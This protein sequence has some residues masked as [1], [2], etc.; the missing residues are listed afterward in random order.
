MT[1]LQEQ[2]VT[3]LK[4]GRIDEAERTF[5]RVLA[6]EPTNIAA[7][8]ALC[9]G[10]LRVG[11]TQRAMELAE[12][13][14]A[15]A[16][17]DAVSRFHLGLACEAAGEDQRGLD[18][19]RKAVE[20][21]ADFHVARLRLANA[22]E[23][24]KDPF[25]AL[26]F[27]RALQDAQRSGRWLDATSTPAALRPLVERGLRT[28]RD[29]R[30]TAYARLLDPLVTEYGASELQR[31]RRC[32]ASY[33]QDERPEYPD[34]RQQPSFLFF[35]G[36]P[37]MPYFDRK[38]F[39]WIPEFER[40]TAEVQHELAHVLSSPEQ[41][42]RVFTDQTLE[43]SNLRG[44]RGPPTWTGYYFYRH[45]IPREDNRASCPRTAELL[46]ALP[47]SHV[48]DHGPEVLFS[49]FTPGTHLL[50]HR[51]VTN[52]RAVGHLP[53][54]VPAD[55]AL[56]VGGEIH[57]WREGEAVVF[58]DTYEHEAWNRSAEVRVVLIFDLW[59]PYLS[60]VERVAVK[61]LVEAIGDF[62]TATDAA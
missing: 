47:L 12:S 51:G 52:T 11:R 41:G 60:P 22:M 28:I 33:L 25:A 13:A 55:C 59:N 42:E 39:D 18:A 62:R 21:R 16:P 30:R 31:V 43:Q 38:L 44:S 4:Q 56:R 14:V 17:Q 48:R 27:A 61:S 6:N 40:H 36:L 9:L 2:A 45:G 15:S 32:I 10:A 5:E 20:L 49:V 54:I 19:F 1:S 50:P 37:A 23:H 26:Q 3:L 57:E 7:L 34:P 24:Q 58:D 35:P 8:N 29:D 46:E 53:L